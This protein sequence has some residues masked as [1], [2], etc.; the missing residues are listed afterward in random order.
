[1]ATSP[2]SS[3][4]AAV[5]HALPGPDDE[6]GR[7]Q[8]RVREPEGEG[9]DRLDAARDEQPVDAEQPGRAE[10]DGVD[11][12]RRDPRARRR[13][14]AA[15]PATCAGTTV[16]TSDD[17]YGAEP[18]GTYAPTRDDGQPAP[19]ELDAR[20]DHRARRGGPLGLGEPADVGDRRLERRPL[21]G[22]ERVGGRGE[23][24]PGRA[25]AGR[26]AARRRSA[27]RRP[28]RP[29]APRARTSAR[30]ARAASRTAGSGTAPRRNRA[31]RSATAAASG[32]RR[33]SRRRRSS[34]STPVTVTG[35]SS[36][37]AARGSRTR[38][39]ALSA[40]SRPQTSSAPT[41]AWIA[42]IPACASGITDG[43]SRPG[44]RSSSSARC[45]GRRVHHQVLAPARRDDRA[46]HR[47]DPVE[48]GRARLQRGGVRDEDRLG[49]Q[50]VADRPEP[51]HRQ[52]RAGRHEV[53]DP[54]RDA[55]PRGDLDRA[56]QRHDVDGD[57]LAREVAPRDVGV[58]RR[59]AVTGEVGDRLVRGVGRHRGGEPAAAVPELAHDRQLGAGLGEQVA[60][61]D[62]QVGHAV[63]D[64]LDHV[65]R[66]HEQDVE[67][68]VLDARHEA[69]VV[70]LEH[71]AGVVEQRQRRVDQAALVGDRQPEALPHRD[72]ASASRTRS[73]I[74][75]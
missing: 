9:A 66:A 48:L 2:A 33:S 29:T 38:P 47:D 26:R 65:A 30:I 16:I 41:T 34:A 4:L 54:L 62:A 68:V 20:D 17:G 6:V 50:D 24:G 1:M 28:G 27:P 46:E 23:L 37:S 75:R 51:V 35:G 7:R 11:A 22:R 8:A 21:R 67:R 43:D 3:T 63:A 56:R 19:L 31:S 42:I 14:S 53:H 40:G 61:R 69:A 74:R 45:V 59:D 71:E 18:P 55:Q 44:S 32:A 60:A 52:R 58:G 5:T 49:G 15:T 39:A 70:L 57:P 73:S 72:G 10:Q 12:R 25:A 36:R 13:R 64:E